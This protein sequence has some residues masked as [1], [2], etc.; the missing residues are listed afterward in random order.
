MEIAPSNTLSPN[1]A[2]PRSQQDH[3]L[4]EL[5]LVAPALPWPR[6]VGAVRRRGAPR[7]AARCAGWTERRGP[8][9]AS[10]P[11]QTEA[12]TLPGGRKLQAESGEPRKNR[13]FG[14][15]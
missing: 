7:G 4:C 15:H 9:R 12:G 3:W 1:I 8:V 6:S 11:N 5:S 2:E 10:L 13:H 14:R